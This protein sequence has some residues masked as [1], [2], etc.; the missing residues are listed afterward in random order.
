MPLQKKVSIVVAI[1]NASLY[2]DEL[3]LSITKQSYSHLEIILIN[4]GSK[5][6]SLDILKRWEIR[7]KR[8]IIVNKENEGVSSARNVG[9]ALATGCYIYFCDSDDILHEN[10]IHFLVENF[11]NNN[12][13][14][15]AC[16]YT[17]D[18]NELSSTSEGCVIFKNYE[19]IEKTLNGD[20]Y[21]WNKMFD[22]NLI[23]RNCIKFNENA[24][25]CEDEEFVIRYLTFA[26]NAIYDKRKLYFYRMNSKGALSQEFSCRRVS[27]IISR[28]NE[29][30]T[31]KASFNS[32]QIAHISYKK[33]IKSN[34]VLFKKICLYLK[35]SKEKKYW[36]NILV[37]VFGK[38]KNDYCLDFT[39]RWNYKDKFFLIIL[40]IKSSHLK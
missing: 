38:Y 14:L 10:L 35:W 16:N 8:I 1:Y 9:I 20:G 27:E 13:N 18:I 7:D 11:E 30:V 4:D 17:R 31:I 28:E 24:H 32:L 19:F 5:D 33:L 6:D 22:L 15:S 2:L 26:R 12:V 29:Y 40:K 36:Q 39:K 23:K 3:L 37:N 25:I 21:L 34:V